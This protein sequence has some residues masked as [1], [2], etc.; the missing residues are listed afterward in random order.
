MRSIPVLVGKGTGQQ[1]VLQN[2]GEWG[3]EGK[4]ADWGRGGKTN[5]SVPAKPRKNPRNIER[6]KD[7]TASQKDR[8]PGGS[9]LD[10]PTA[11]V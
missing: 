8:T 9:G 3:G 10:F 4:P 1:A 2:V 7:E 11:Q 5:Q 6:K